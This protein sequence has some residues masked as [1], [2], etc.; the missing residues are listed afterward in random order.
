MPGLR[1]SRSDERQD[2][3]RRSELKVFLGL[4]MGIQSVF[5]YLVLRRPA[6]P[7]PHGLVPERCSTDRGDRGGRYTVGFCWIIL[8]AEVAGRMIPQARNLSIRMIEQNPT[9]ERRRA[10]TDM[11]RPEFTHVLSY[12]PSSEEPR[13]AKRPRSKDR[14]Q[15]AETGG[16]EPPVELCPTLH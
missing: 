10:G 7:P 16:F 3:S 8:F 6:T 9:S 2:V 13:N 15:N 5:A 12:N 11:P 1:A 4:L 14:G